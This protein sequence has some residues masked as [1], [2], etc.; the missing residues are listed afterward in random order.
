MIGDRQESR[1]PKR[2]NSAYRTLIK[3]ILP[4]SRTQFCLKAVLIAT[5]LSSSAAIAQAPSSQP[6]TKPAA[7]APS[8]PSTATQVEKWTNKQWEAA[9]K[10]WAKDKKN[11]ADC[12]MQSREQKLEGRKSWSFIY[13]CMTS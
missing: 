13:K 6:A 12:R 8:N 9:K 3:E 1:A 2:R 11:W 4:M 5:I 7:A 10:R